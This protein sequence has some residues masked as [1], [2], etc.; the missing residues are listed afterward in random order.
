VTTV[1]YLVFYNSII[2]STPGPPTEFINAP[3]LIYYVKGYIK[4]EEF[5][6]AL[7]G[8]C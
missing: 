8:I 1:P 4:T 5:S 2:I 3:V 7:P 6:T